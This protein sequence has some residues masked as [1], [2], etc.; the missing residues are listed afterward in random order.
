MPELEDIHACWSLMPQIDKKTGNHTTA[1]LFALG[2]YGGDGALRELKKR[3][4]GEI[5]HIGKP[6]V[7]CAMYVNMIMGWAKPALGYK[8]RLKGTEVV[9]NYAADKSFRQKFERSFRLTGED[10]IADIIEETWEQYQKEGD[11]PDGVRMDVEEEITA[12]LK[13]KYCP[14]GLEHTD[15]SQ[16]EID[17]SKLIALELG[18]RKRRAKPAAPA[19]EESEPLEAKIRQELEAKIRQEHAG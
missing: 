15:F 14:P 12:I 18:K 16:A 17:K 11:I 9:V 7:G 8:E 3:C 5:E 13:D 4:D 6:L 10:E 1:G 19:P 2:G